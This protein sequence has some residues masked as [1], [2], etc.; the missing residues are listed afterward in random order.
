MIAG[1]FGFILLLAHCQSTHKWLPHMNPVLALKG[2]SLESVDVQVLRHSLC[3]IPITIGAA[4][5]IEGRIIARVPVGHVNGVDG[6]GSLLLLH[7]GGYHT[8]V[9]T[10]RE[11]DNGC[12]AAAS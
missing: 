12:D 3:I 11:S 2:Q 6:L 5:Y 7:Q 4:G 8:A 9:D 1:L 10:P